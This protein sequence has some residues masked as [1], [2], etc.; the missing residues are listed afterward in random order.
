MGRPFTR[1]ALLAAVG[2]AAIAGCVGGGP[3]SETAREDPSEPTAAK[4]G[5]PTG[6]DGRRSGGGPPTAKQ[7]LPLPLAPSAIRDRA[8]SGGPPKDGIPSIDDPVFEPVDEVDN[9]LAPGD[10]VFGVSSGNAAKAYPQSILVWHEICNDTIGD[11]PVSVTY[12]PLTGTAMGFERGETTFGVSGRLVNN[13]LIM[14]DR[15][16]ETWWP[17]VLATAVPG[18]WNEDPR[19]ESLSEFRV[20]WTTWRRWKAAYPDTRVL[21]RE[22]GFARN[23]DRDPYGS[24]NPRGGYYAPDAAPMFRSL[25]Q[26][27]RLPPKAVV[28]GTRNPNG[29]AAFRKQHLRRAKLVDGELGN[30]PVVAVYDAAL[31]TGYVYRNPD[32]VPLEYRDGTVRTGDGEAHQPGDVPL[33]RV[34]AFD[35]MWFAWSGFYPDTSLHA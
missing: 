31:D 24:Y 35:A 12:C 17:Q 32:E 23:Y 22:T 9:R 25:S 10:P 8:V 29:A 18:P 6:T 34:L 7:R 11:R 26:D 3:S 1:R 21:T 27:D 19:I 14:Y 13:N 5:S 2:S 33:E 15:A 20:V 30:T 28:I 4:H 16:T